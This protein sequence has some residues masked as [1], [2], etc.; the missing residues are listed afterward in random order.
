MALDFV[1][2][3]F[4]KPFRLRTAL[5]A[6]T[7]LAVATVISAPGPARAQD[8]TWLANPG[9]ADFNTGSNWSSSSVPTGT[10]YFDATSTSSLAFSTGPTTVGGWTFNTGASNYT[11][12]NNNQL[13]FNGA[14]IAVN[15]G[16]VTINSNNE[17]IFF[18]SSTAGNAAINNSDDLQF[19]DTSTAGTAAIT[20]NNTLGFVTSSTAGSATITNNSDLGFYDSTTAGSATITNS[21]SV[22]FHGNST[23]GSAQLINNG[24][25]AVF[26]FSG[27][28][29]PNGDNKLSAGSIAGDG[30]F[31]LGA[32]ELT[33]GS[34]NLSTEVSGVISGSG[35]LVKTGTGTLILTGANTYTGGTTI[36]GSGSELWLG[37]TTGGVGSILGAVTVGSGSLFKIVNAD[38]SGITTITN[39][40]FTFFYNATS[41]SSATITNN[42]VLNFFNTSTAGSATITNNANLNFYGTSTAG[43][44]TFTN[45]GYG[46][47]SFRDS[48]TAGSATITNDGT[49]GFYDTS[50]AGSAAITNTYSMLFYGSSTA[51][52]ATIINN[53]AL[54]FRDAAS[55]GSATITSGSSG[56]FGF[57]GTSTAGSATITNSGSMWFNDTSTAGSASI[58]N[59]GTLTFYNATTAGD[60]TI[61]NSNG[62]TTEFRGNSTAGNAQLINNGASAAFDFSGTVGPNSD[63]K[64]SAGSIAGDGTF[65]LGANEL[66]VGGNNL[67]TTVSG[68][69]SGSGSLVKTGTGTMTL[70]GTNTY[71]GGTTFA[72][73]TVS[74]SSDANLGG[75]A[76]SL[77]FNGGSLQVTG[78]AFTSTARAITLGAGGGT[79]DIADA[80]NS[81]S[82]TQG[83]T[84]TG[85]LTK[86][87][88]GTLILSGANTYTGA[89][90]VSAGILDIQ[91]SIASSTV[92]NN[93]RLNYSNSTTAGSASITNNAGGA[94]V[95]YGTST[96]GNAN[97]TNNAILNFNSG[98]TAGNATITNNADLTFS[99]SSTG[100][101]ASITNFNQL[102]FY[103]NTSAGSATI[104]NFGTMQFD[105]NST[106]GS[107]QLINSGSSAVV[108]FW[109]PGPA[110]DG[111]I[112][113][114]S[115]A[116]GGR[117]DLN[118]TELTV[119]SNNLSTEVTGVLTGDGLTTGASLIKTGTGTLTLSGTNTYTGATTVDSGTLLVNGSIASSPL[120]LVN[121]G[122]TLGGTGTVATTFL[123]SGATLAP[124]TPGSIGTLTVQGNLTFCNCSI[125]AVKVSPTGADK[126]VVTG[127]AALGGTVQAT[128]LAGS[129][130]GQTYTI[131]NATGGLGGTQFDSLTFTGSSISPGARNPHLTYDADN[132]YLV[133]DPGTLQL[134]SGASGNQ[135]SVAG[136]INNAV[137][138]GGTPPSGFDT[139]LNLSG[140]QQTNALNQLSGQPGAA[141]TQSAFDAMRQFMTMLGGSADSGE[142]GVTSFAD[143]ALGYASA[144][145]RNAKKSEAY[146]AVTPRDRRA[147][148][149][150]RR[151]GVWASGYGGSSTINGSTSS[152]TSTTTSRVYGTVVGA[153]YRATPDTLIGF[154]LG[155][156]GFNF[157]LADGL[158]SG[159]AD[160]FQMGLYG[161]HNLGAAY[162]AASLAYGWQDVTTDRTVTVSGVDK[163]TANYKASTFAARGETGWRFAPLP[164]SGV[165]VTPYAALQVTSFRL[166]GYSE[167]ATSGSNTFALFYNAQTTTNVRTELG[168]HLDRPF[169]VRDG[170]FTVRGRVAWAHDS[171]T[172]RPVTAT[173]QTLP[174]STFTTNGAKPT[175]DA[176]LI[177]AGAKMDW[178]NGFS[179]AGTFEGE[180]SATTRSYA[181]KATLHYAW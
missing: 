97:I 98:S 68:V 6:S 136:G 100:G 160:L 44:A 133:L 87:G 56:N 65:N 115:L 177:G 124:G 159:R 94:I 18:N 102:T 35:S 37:N 14:G 73:G 180:F 139:L 61:T 126:T 29:G 121:P 107:A 49:F 147:V 127:Q 174:G 88:A 110:S 99:D 119:G 91:D 25:S 46:L 22:T 80:A 172:D 34:N 142:G 166:P 131:L 128:A 149:F 7:A 141:I 157:S 179:L 132:V 158:G 31:Y 111:R 140:S 23:A 30:T 24:A 134:S 15:G 101:N 89:T 70:S 138:N 114:G 116:G 55:A 165:G 40:G 146:A 1:K 83:M 103:G 67:S 163:L 109:T 118:S 154:A 143:E 162:V 145:K 113:A 63:N 5:L 62:H 66:T 78:T 130:R 95:F 135:S 156:A 117:F 169:L 96:A 164:A 181:G 173:F 17:L 168:S 151:W 21:H 152:G 64:V 41:A 144:G 175:A 129:F 10:A 112:T 47:T 69:I 27:S 155:G 53:Y 178:L 11:F 86:T 51:G 104:N 92:T 8:A 33:V 76:G 20:N 120:V 36:S 38:T 26:D 2:D 52:S 171:N 93:A 32:N 167:T 19:F 108:N 161:R 13:Y 79:F 150:E 90:T 123:D 82:V 60:A 106:A 176:A 3:P 48:S 105:G 125:Y 137:L 42:N 72:G 153:D 170:L 75:A 122:A 59:S 9:S 58:G 39:N 54:T 43:T 16:S 84:G 50:S 74:V 4:G 57:Y 77:T 28:T 148:S 12:T 81:F 85:G 71:T 45:T